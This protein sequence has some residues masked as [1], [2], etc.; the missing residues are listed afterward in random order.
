MLS[1][2]RLQA[3]LLPPAAQ[4]IPGLPEVSFTAQQPS[5][6][7]FPTPRILIP[8]AS[9]AEDGAATL[10][11]LVSNLDVITDDLG[12]PPSLQ[13]SAS[14]LWSPA[15]GRGFARMNS[16][17]QVEASAR[18]GDDASELSTLS[19]YVAL[20]VYQQQMQVRGRRCEERCSV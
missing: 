16:G 3:Q 8:S 6:L 12:V 11:A 1:A 13:A 2:S 20:H 10:G 7:L 9:D 18:A 5:D 4:P 15:D 19:G 17:F 14:P